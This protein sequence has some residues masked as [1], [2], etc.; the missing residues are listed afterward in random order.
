R[1]AQETRDKPSKIIQ[2]NIIN[3]PEAIRPYLPSTNACCRKIQ[4]VRHAGLPPQLQN[5]AEFDN[6]IDLYPPRIIT[7]FEVTAI[8]ASRF[9]FPGVIN[10]A[11]F[12]HLRQNRWK[13]IQKCGLASK[14]R[15]DTCFSI[16]VR[17]LF[18]LAFL[19]PSE[20][21]SAFNILKPQMPQE[22]RELVL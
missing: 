20:I 22:A 14:Y 13:K 2:E 7:D 3:T 8:N 19:P 17:C 4:R 9:M 12:F 11:C 6:E 1:Q 18:A 21:P 10:K 5:I 15:N 16:K